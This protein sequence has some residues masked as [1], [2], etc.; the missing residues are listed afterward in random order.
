MLHDNGLSEDT[1][2]IMAQFGFSDTLFNFIT[3]LLN[4]WTIS[5]SSFVAI[6]FRMLSLATSIC[7]ILIVF[8][9]K[10][11]VMEGGG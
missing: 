11:K 7:S 4:V 9:E 2:S 3:A 8:V 10:R 6:T 5:V 1:H